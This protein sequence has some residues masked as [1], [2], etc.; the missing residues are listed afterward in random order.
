VHALEATV[1]AIAAHGNAAAVGSKAAAKRQLYDERRETL[2][3]VREG[4]RADGRLIWDGTKVLEAVVEFGVQMNQPRSANR[5]MA[6]EVLQDGLAHVG[7]PA[8]GY[9]RPAGVPGGQRDWVDDV[10]SRNN[11]ETALQ[12]MRQDQS[13]GY[14]A[15]R[16]VTLKW[17]PEWMRAR[18]HQT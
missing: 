3:V 9:P 5:E 18:Y 8:I 16:G 6:M 4:D 12:R 2:L 17:A 13:P 7:L 1:Y 10:L 14:D 15:W 11:F